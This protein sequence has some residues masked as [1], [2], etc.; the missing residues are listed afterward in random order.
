[1]HVLVLT[2]ES[3]SLVKVG[4]II[5]VVVSIPNDLLTGTEKKPLDLVDLV[6]SLNPFSVRDLQFFFL[7]SEIY[8]I[9]TEIDNL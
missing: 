2:I 7:C 8:L 1:M 4:L 5:C 6:L 3:L 9:C